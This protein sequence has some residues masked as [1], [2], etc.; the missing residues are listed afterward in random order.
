MGCDYLPIACLL[1]NPKMWSSTC[2]CQYSSI[3]AEAKVTVRR[4]AHDVYFLYVCIVS[5]ASCIPKAPM[6]IVSTA[7][8]V[9]RCLSYKL[10]R[11]YLTCQ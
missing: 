10:K 7:R 8:L 5:T 11:S 6:A 9:S 2:G 1:G 3:E 4:P